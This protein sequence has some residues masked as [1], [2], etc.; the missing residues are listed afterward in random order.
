MVSV[1]MVQAGN[2]SRLIAKDWSSMLMA[3]SGSLMNMVPTFVSISSFVALSHIGI[4][5]I[6]I[7]IAYESD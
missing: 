1:V 5:E 6:Y 3:L 2:A 7:Q 4:D